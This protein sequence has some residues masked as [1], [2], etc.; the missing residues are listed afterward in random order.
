MGIISDEMRRKAEI[1]T[2]IDRY[3]ERLVTEHPMEARAR[4]TIRSVAEEMKYHLF[5]IMA[6]K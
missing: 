1:S 3:V 4:D 5:D 6:Q 2:V